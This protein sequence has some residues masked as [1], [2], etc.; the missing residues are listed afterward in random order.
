[1]V[2]AGVTA[3]RRGVLERVQLL[4]EDWLLTKARLADAEQRMTGVVDQLA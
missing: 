2:P 4:L 3:H 1:V